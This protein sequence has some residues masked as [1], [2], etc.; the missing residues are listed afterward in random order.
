MSE[1][2]RAIVRKAADEWPDA[3]VRLLAY[4]VSQGRPSDVL[5]ECQSSK[6]HGLGATSHGPRALPATTASQWAR[7]GIL[8]VWRD[9]S[10]VLGIKALPAPASA[11]QSI[12]EATDARR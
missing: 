2:M 5:A 1:D 3:D 6:A 11:W 8:A 4:L 10:A 7:S 9:I 12:D